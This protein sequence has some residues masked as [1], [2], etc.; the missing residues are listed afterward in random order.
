MSNQAR[1]YL[2]V[3]VCTILKHIGA[4][5]FVCFVYY[6]YEIKSD[7]IYLFS[8]LKVASALRAKIACSAVYSLGCLNALV[9]DI[10]ECSAVDYVGECSIS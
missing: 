5:T 8:A 10:C 2:I 7:V 6:E 9:Y 1:F 3:H 4:H